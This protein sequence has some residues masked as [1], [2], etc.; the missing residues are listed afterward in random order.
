MYAYVIQVVP[1][2][3]HSSI[4]HSWNITQ[5]EWIKKP[6][7]QMIEPVIQDGNAK[8]LLKHQKKEYIALIALL[9]IDL[10]QCSYFLFF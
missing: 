9:K 1:I 7:L 10:L 6:T 3:N 2:N 8:Q 4:W 5:Q